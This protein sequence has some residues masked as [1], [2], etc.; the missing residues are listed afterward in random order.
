MLFRESLFLLKKWIMA[1]K[2]EKGQNK[3]W[4]KTKIT[5]IKNTENMTI[6]AREEK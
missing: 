1:E 2:L 3:E 5:R 6:T 4:R